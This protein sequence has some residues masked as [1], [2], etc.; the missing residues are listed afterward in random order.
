MMKNLL[1]YQSKTLTGAALILAVASVMSRVVG[2]A[3]DRILAHQFGAGTELDIYTA[4]FRIPDFIYNLLIVGALSAGFIP[5][6][7]ELFQK[8]KKSAWKFASNVVNATFIGVSITS[9]VLFLFTP[10]L[11]ELLVP[12]FA[13]EAKQKAIELTRIM[14]FSPILLGLSAVVSGVLQSLKAFFIYS[15]APVLYN[16]GII[17]GSIFLVPMFGLAGLAYGVVL[18]ALLHLVIQIPVLLNSGFRYSPFLSFK[19]SQTK[20]LL[21]AFLPR[22][23]TL[24]SVQVTTLFLT[25]FASFL[26]AGSIAIFHFA[27]NIS[28]LPIGIIGISFAIAAFPTLS[29]YVAQKDFDG[30]KKQ[31]SLTTRQ[32]LF[33]ILPL[34][35]LFILLRAQIVR[36]LLGSGEFNWEDTIMTA[37]TVGMFSLS[38]F[39]QCLLAL[40]SR[41]FFALHNVRTPLIIALFSMAITVFLSFVF[42]QHFGVA[43][44][45]LGISLGSIVQVSLLYM[46]LR[47][48]LGPSPEES[49]ILS[50]I[51]KLSLCSLALGITTQS[52]KYPISL[53]VNMDTFLGIFLQ[54]LICGLVGLLVYG[55]LAYF[56][57]VPE[58][59]LLTQ[60][61]RK[62]WLKLRNVPSET[63]VL[64]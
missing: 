2:V 51:T 50:V 18:G 54:G 40:Y 23:L 3:R 34:T 30:F 17:L 42:K 7:L 19:D 1:S 8:E 26:G 49:S 41:A 12:G 60:S 13:F 10:F 58:L 5:L 33:F 9:A 35:V 46:R 52:L 31:L 55:I 27:N 53:L 38:L 28:S 43:G 45:A 63:D 56:L 32:I 16:V 4:A 37:T 61:L 24:A 44:L 57:K 64:K 48:T 11:V 14:L 39:S 36:V 20:K 29:E 15:L 22:T 6:F 62:K 21:H 47:Q 59:S 25:F